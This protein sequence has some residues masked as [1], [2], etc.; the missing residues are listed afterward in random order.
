MKVLFP[1]LKGPTTPDAV[2]T[3]SEMC[4]A[5][6]ASA[7]DLDVV[8]DD[9]KWSRLYDGE[10][11]WARFAR[12][13]QRIIDDYLTSAHD[14]VLWVDYDVNYNSDLFD[15]LWDP[16]AITSP[17][18][19]IEGI[20]THYDTAGTRPSFTERSDIAPPAPGVY[21]MFSVGC[22]VCVPAEVHR[23]RRVKFAPQ[24]DD[25][26]TANTEWTSLCHAARELG[27]RVE[28][29][30]NIVVEHANLPWYGQEWH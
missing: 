24:A 23:S 2:Q 8:V 11:Y 14:A 17:L 15:L 26:L 30:T 16:G 29:R 22:V 6:L 25:D 13:R 4:R 18:V 10:N 21:P 9:S 19:I 7:V 28:W 27:Y 5:N 12:A 3:R 1:V 20:E